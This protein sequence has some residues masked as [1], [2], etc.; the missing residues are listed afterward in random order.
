[1]KKENETRL[2]KFLAFNLGIS[3]RKADSLIENGEIRINDEI[4]TIGDRVDTNDIVFVNN[5]KIEL[6]KN[7]EY[8][9]LNKPIGYVCSR[10]KQGEDPTIYSLLPENLRHLKPV[11]RLDKNSSGLIILTDDGDFTHS[12][13]HPSFYKIKSY[14]VKLDKNLEPLHRQMINDYGIKLPDG[15]SKLQ[16]SRVKDDDNKLWNVQMS[17]GRNRQIRRTFDALGYKVVKL[18]RTNFG[19]YRLEVLNLKKG[20]FKKF[21]KT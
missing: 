19:S 16:L 15:P 12:M 5:R 20:E 1:M 17:E 13:T 3:R 11:G 14:I 10:K 2:N 4:A 6:K 9:A 8:I 21:K 18:H 7:F